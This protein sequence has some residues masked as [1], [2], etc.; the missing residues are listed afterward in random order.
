MINKVIYCVCYETDGHHPFYLSIWQCVNAFDLVALYF[1][2]P[3]EKN[4]H[5]L[6]SLP[7]NLFIK[8]KKKFGYTALIRLADE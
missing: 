7:E 6:F 8:I 2:G 3:Q 4:T 1:S 5:L